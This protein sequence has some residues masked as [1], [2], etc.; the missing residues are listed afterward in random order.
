MN[1]RTVAQ[2]RAERKLGFIKVGKKPRMASAM[3]QD[4]APLAIPP[5]LQRAPGEVRNP[6]DIEPHPFAAT[7][8][9]LQ[10]EDFEALAAETG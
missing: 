3:P 6:G 7:F 5:E 8:P 9:M 10:G 1:A 2:W 4:S